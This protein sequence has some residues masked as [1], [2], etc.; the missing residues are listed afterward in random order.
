M[1]SLDGHVIKSANGYP[2]TLNFSA[3][4]NYPLSAV[5][6]QKAYVPATNQKIYMAV[7]DQ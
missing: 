2:I 5:T 3:D 1:K 4:Y 7:T 6:D